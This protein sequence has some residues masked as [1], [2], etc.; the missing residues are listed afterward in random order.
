MST[1]N[2]GK[3]GEEEAAQFLLD[4]GIE[5]LTRNFRAGKAGEVDIIAKDGNIFVF[6][7]VKSFQIYSLTKPRE[8]VTISKQEKIKYVAQFYLMK[9]NL[10]QVPCRFDVL[11]VCVDRGEVKEI[12]WL[13]DAFR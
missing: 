5:I 10:R 9:N 7:E 13:K 6:V 12:N 1:F 8:A 3:K 2:K 11:E 4:K